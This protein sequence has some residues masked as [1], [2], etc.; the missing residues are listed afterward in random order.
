[1]ANFNTVRNHAHS[2]SNNDDLAACM[3]VGQVRK[4]R[5]TVKTPSNP[6]GSEQDWD[7]SRSM[8]DTCAKKGSVRAGGARSADWGHAR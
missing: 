1:M 3:N 7:R 4:H 6:G 2:V 8:S 5:H